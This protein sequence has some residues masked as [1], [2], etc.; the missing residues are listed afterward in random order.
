MDIQVQGNVLILNEHSFSVDPA[1]IGLKMVVTSLVLGIL[2]LARFERKYNRRLK[3]MELS[4][5][6][7]AILSGAVVANFI[8]LLTL[9][10]F[11]ILPDN[12]MHDLVGLLSLGLYVLLPFYFLVHL[13]FEKKAVGETLVFNRPFL[14]LTKSSKN[15]LSGKKSKWVNLAFLLT[16]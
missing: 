13:V 9:V 5:L 6:L 15:T 10:L 2:I 4:F 3:F 11:H 14:N 16:T 7:G 12:P 1:C 8:R